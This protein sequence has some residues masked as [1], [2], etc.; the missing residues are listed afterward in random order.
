VGQLEVA[1]V[2][3]GGGRERCRVKG[4]V[5]VGETETVAGPIRRCAR[6]IVYL[7]GKIDANHFVCIPLYILK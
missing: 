6:P 7:V 4:G 2:K 3:H 5:L 1:V